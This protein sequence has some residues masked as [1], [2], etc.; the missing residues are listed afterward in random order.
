MN[1]LKKFEKSLLLHSNVLYYKD[2]QKGSF[3]EYLPGSSVGFSVIESQWIIPS[4]PV[5]SRKS[6]V[7]ASVWMGTHATEAGAY[8]ASVSEDTWF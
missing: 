8:R 2:Y 7:R 4:F 1:N 3:I 5:D 6:C